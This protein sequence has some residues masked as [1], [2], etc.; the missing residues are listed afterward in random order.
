[1][2]A[3]GWDEKGGG[4]KLEKGRNRKYVRNGRSIRGMGALGRERRNRNGR[5]KA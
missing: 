3:E 4:L 5:R 2:K 1:M